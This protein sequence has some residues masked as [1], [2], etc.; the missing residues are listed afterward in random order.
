MLPSVHAAPE[1]L[2]LDDAGGVITTSQ[3][4]PPERGARGL[5]DNSPGGPPQKRH[6]PDGPQFAPA[7]AYPPQIAAGAVPYV[8]AGHHHMPN[9]TPQHMLEPSPFGDTSDPVML[10]AAGAGTGALAA[11]L[12]MSAPFQPPPETQAP[13][14]WGGGGD[15]LRDG[16]Q[17][18]PHQGTASALQE[19]HPMVMLEPTPLNEM[20]GVN[21]MATAFGSGPTRA[22]DGGGGGGSGVPPLAAAAFLS[23]LSSGDPHAAHPGSHGMQPGL[24]RLLLCDAFPTLNYFLLPGIRSQRTGQPWPSARCVSPFAAGG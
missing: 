24:S 11:A 16:G 19:G 12:R 8:D 7:P 21:E 17:G 9:V 5:P 13:H 3:P 6:H 20:H 14:G 2:V 18:I 15:E 10:A 4:G 22:F 1:G 23:A